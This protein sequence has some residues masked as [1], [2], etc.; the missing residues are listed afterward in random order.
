MPLNAAQIEEGRKEYLKRLRAV[1]RKDSAKKAEYDA[2]KALHT[3]DDLVEA[4]VG[5]DGGIG[6][7]AVA[8]HQSIPNDTAAGNNPRAALGAMTHLWAEFMML[9]VLVA[10]RSKY[11]VTD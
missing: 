6:A 1:I 2:A 10:I 4:M 7:N 3:V 8:M 5:L 9:E 11:G